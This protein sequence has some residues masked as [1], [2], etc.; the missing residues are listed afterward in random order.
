MSIDAMKQA[1]EALTYI[2]TETTKDEDELIHAAIAALRLA[3][4]QVERQEPVRYCDI[5]NLPEP[6]VQCAK[7]HEGYNTPPQRQLVV[8]QE[9]AERGCMAHDDRVDGPGV[10]IGGEE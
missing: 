7:E 1:L 5:H 6:C 10:V 3:I 8:S 4:E 9:C 2:H